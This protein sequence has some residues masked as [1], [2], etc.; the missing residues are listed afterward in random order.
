MRPSEGIPYNEEL[1]G[2]PFASDD[3]NSE[4]ITNHVYDETK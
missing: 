2:K 1:F 4:D 3:E